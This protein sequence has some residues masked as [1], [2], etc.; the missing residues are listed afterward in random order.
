MKSLE[1][2]CHLAA[3]LAERM[4]QRR[5]HGSTALTQTRRHGTRGMRKSRQGTDRQDLGSGASAGVRHE[6]QQYFGTGKHKNDQDIC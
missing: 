2:V 3:A 4:F 5:L 6:C 1:R